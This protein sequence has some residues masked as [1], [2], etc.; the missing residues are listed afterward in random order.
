[1]YIYTYVTQ[2][3][4]APEIHGSFWLLLLHLDGFWAIEDWIDWIPR[5][6]QESAEEIDPGTSIYVDRYVMVYV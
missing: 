1:M 2:H 6:S 4:E 3:N 5:I